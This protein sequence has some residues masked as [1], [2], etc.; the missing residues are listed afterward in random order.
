MHAGC[1]LEVAIGEGERSWVATGANTPHGANL[2]VPVENTEKIGDDVIVYEPGKESHISERGCD[3]KRGETVL[4]TGCIVNDRNIGIL[5]A[6]G[7]RIVPLHDAPWHAYACWH[8]GWK[9]DSLHARE[10]NVLSGLRTRISAPDD[11]ADGASAVSRE[12]ETCKIV[13]GGGLGV[14]DAPLS[15]G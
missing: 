2:V 14:R 10:C 6:L 3:I 13:R 4:R 8:D 1:D 11:P 9:T 7:N 12:Y 5:A 15:S